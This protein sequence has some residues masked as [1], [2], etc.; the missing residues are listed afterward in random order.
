MD[1]IRT[2]LL[3]AIEDKTNAYKQLSIKDIL[4]LSQAVKNIYDTGATVEIGKDGISFT[5]GSIIYEDDEIAIGF[6]D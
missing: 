3:K 2:N 5:K 4:Y 6:C 1:K